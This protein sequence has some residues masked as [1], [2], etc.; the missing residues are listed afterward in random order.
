[1]KSAIE[2]YQ[3]PINARGLR[4]DLQVPD[5]TLMA[6]R[7]EAE[8]DPRQPVLECRE[9]HAGRRHDHAARRARPDG[10]ADSRSTSQ[11]PGPA[12][13]R[14]SAPRIFEAFYQGATPQGG[15]VRGTGIGLSVV[16]EFAQAHGGTV[17][18]VDDE[19][20]GAHF[21]VRLPHGARS[22]ATRRDA[23]DCAERLQSPAHVGTNRNDDGQR[24]TFPR[25][26]VRSAS[27]LRRCAV[28]ACA[29]RRCTGLQPTPRLAARRSRTDCSTETDR[30]RRPT[31]TRSIDSRP[32]ISNAR[33][34]NC[35]LTQSGSAT[36]PDRRP[37]A[38]AM[39]SRSA[40]PAIPRAIRSKHGD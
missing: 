11:T 38:C 14:R 6:D 12:F 32:A 37:I 20:S 8:A 27:T 33:R 17:E 24:M 5:L 21:R 34:P 10:T 25:C 26:T 3:L 23:R 35:A 30:H 18:I 29:V 15:L 4:L 13:R 28:H 19:F 40:R 22:P 2:T 1:M 39:R 9:V 36:E 31:G 16:Q 7:D